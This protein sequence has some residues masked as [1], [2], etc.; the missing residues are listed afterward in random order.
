QSLDPNFPIPL[1]HQLKDIFMEKIQSEEWAVGNLI[2][3][4]N[5]LIEQYEVSRTTV[6]EAINILVQEGYLQK[7]QG[8]GTF[9]CK[10]KIVERLSCL[11]GFAE[12][13]KK[14]GMVPSAKLIHYDELPSSHPITQMMD[15][16]M[17]HS[18][19]LIKRIRFANDE[20]IAIENSYW[21]KPI[22]TLFAEE[23]LESVAFYEIL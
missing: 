12:E 15:L 16:N 5:E 2:P 7:K 4:E 14:R 22:G 21:P 11:T 8:K 6:R 1:Y 20:V 10:P 13:I 3:T 23:N 18:V 9:I 17:E 19:I